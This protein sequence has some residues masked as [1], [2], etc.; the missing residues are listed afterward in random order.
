DA[1]LTDLISPV[2]PGGRTGPDPVSAYNPAISADGRL[3]TYESSAGN[4]N[5]AKRYGRIGAL[6]CDLGAHATTAVDDPSAGVPESLSAYNPVM[7]AGGTRMI[8]EAVRDG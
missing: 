7:A 4:Q 5:F 8:Y 2:A 1:S 6:L 3:V